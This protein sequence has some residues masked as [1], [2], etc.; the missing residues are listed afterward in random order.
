MTKEELRAAIDN[1]RRGRSVSSDDMRNILV[2][3]M[4]YI[5]SLEKQISSP[6]ASK[7]EG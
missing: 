5:E 1:V 4:E 6:R 2:G 3:I 7:E